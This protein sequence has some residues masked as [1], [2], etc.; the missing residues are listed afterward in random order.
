MKVERLLSLKGG[1]GIEYG[2]ALRGFNTVRV[3]WSNVIFLSKATFC[4]IASSF[5]PIDS[6]GQ[7]T[8]EGGHRLCKN[9]ILSGMCAFMPCTQNHEA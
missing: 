2:D 4:N 1:E 7:L 3:S 5:S 8:E 6:I 9:F